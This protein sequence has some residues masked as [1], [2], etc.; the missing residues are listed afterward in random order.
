MGN[1]S[2]SFQKK[3]VMKAGRY[4]TVYVKSPQEKE[5]AAGILEQAM[6]TQIMSMTQTILN[7][8]RSELY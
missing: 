7:F 8:G 1:D 4:V 2:N 5:T 6:K 3:F